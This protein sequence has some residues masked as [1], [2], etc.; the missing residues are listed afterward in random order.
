[1]ADEKCSIELSSPLA[2]HVS[3]F[4]TYNGFTLLELMV[5]VA[6]V[7]I[8]IAMSYA[9]YVG[10]IRHAR[11]SNA[12]SALEQLNQAMQIY[13]TQHYSYLGTVGANNAPSSAVLPYSATP[14]HGTP[15]YYNLLITSLSKTSYT[16][17]AQPVPGSDQVWDDC[18]TLV[19][20]SDGTK[21]VTG[22]QAKCW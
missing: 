4:G 12:E 9:T 8:L 21:S 18:G 1:M 2:Q 10:Y 6:I 15:K 13:Y 17:E 14:V 5:V 16:L 20:K 19:V 3:R 11:R 22:S 7:G